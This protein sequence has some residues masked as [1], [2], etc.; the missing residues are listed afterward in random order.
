[1]ELV[2]KNPPGSARDIRDMGF[3]HG[4]GRSPREISTLL[5]LPGESHEQRSLAG[6]GPWGLSRTRLK[7]LNTHTK[8]SINM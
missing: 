7:Q 6:Y 1:M 5:F 3:I 2:V 8:P 4:L